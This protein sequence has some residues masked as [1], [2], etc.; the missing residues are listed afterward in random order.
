MKLYKGIAE[1]R[2]APK[3]CVVSI[4]NFDG[5]HLGHRALL[6]AAVSHAASIGGTALAFT[7]R[8]HPRFLLRPQ[9]AP[10]LLN[11]YEERLELLVS[12]GISVVVEEPFTPEF[13]GIS[14][15]RFVEQYILQALQAKALYLGHDFAFGKGRAGSVETIRS[16]VGSKG[17]ETFVVPAFSIEGQT[18]SSTQIRQFLDDGKIAEANRF[19]GRPVFLRGV[20]SRGDGRG[21][22]IGVPTANLHGEMRKFP[23]TGVY[24]TRTICKGKQFKSITNIGFNPTFKGESDQLPLKIETHIFDFEADIYGET[25]HVDFFAFLR[26]EQKFSGVDALLTQMRKDFSDAREI[27]A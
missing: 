23:R 18:V 15:D 17:V 25:I 16:L 14:A 27:L 6:N 24:A 12:A 26:A 7:F 13:S 2:S 21:R 20:V 4:G 11:T 1:L 5:V 22:Q 8:P 10:Q 3:N 19:L 9:D